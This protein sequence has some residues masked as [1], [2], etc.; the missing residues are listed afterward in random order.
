VKVIRPIIDSD[1][2]IEYIAKVY[3]SRI[4]FA[5]LAKLSDLIWSTFERAIGFYHKF[6]RNMVLS[7]FSFEYL[8]NT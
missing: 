4:D 6:R 8:V 1:L 2:S 3:L 5:Y 7:S